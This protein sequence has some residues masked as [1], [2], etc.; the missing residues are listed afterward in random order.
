M[1]TQKKENLREAIISLIN[2]F[3]PEYVDLA[4]DQDYSISQL[5]DSIETFED[6]AEEGLEASEEKFKVSLPPEY[7]ELKSMLEGGF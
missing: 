2:S 5:L 3:S 7:Y 4:E 6:E 1:T